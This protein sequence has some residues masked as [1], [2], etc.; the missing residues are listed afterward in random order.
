MMELRSVVART[1]EKYEVRMADE[2]FDERTFHDGILD[3]FTAGVPR[4]EVVFQRR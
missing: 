4:C 3:H 1:I 2:N